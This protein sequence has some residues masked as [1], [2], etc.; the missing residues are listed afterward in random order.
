[1]ESSNN[2]SDS[3]CLTSMYQASK[4]VED[5]AKQTFLFIDTKYNLNELTPAGRL[6][7]EALTILFSHYIAASMQT[8]PN[9]SPNSKKWYAWTKVT[10]V[11]HHWRVVALGSPGLWTDIV[12]QNQAIVEEFLRRSGSAPLHIKVPAKQPNIDALVSVLASFNHIRSIEFLP[13]PYPYDQ[14]PEAS[15]PDEAGQIESIILRSSSKPVQPTPTVFNKCDLSSLRRLH[16]EGFLVDWLH[17][18]FTPNLTH[19]Y[20]TADPQEGPEHSTTMAAMVKSLESMTSLRSLEFHNI[21]FPEWSTSLWD[22]N[23]TTFPQT[24]HLPALKHLTLVCNVSACAYLLRLLRFAGDVTLQIETTAS[25]LPDSIAQRALKFFAESLYE[26]FAESGTLQ[27]PKA[28]EMR[29]RWKTGFRCWNIPFSYQV[30]KSTAPSLSVTFLKNGKKPE[31]VLNAV[32]I[33]VPLFDETLIISAT[34]SPK[35][36]AWA[37]I[38]DKMFHVTRIFVS[39]GAW[40]DLPKMLSMHHISQHRNYDSKS[41]SDLVLQSLETIHFDDGEFNPKVGVSFDRLIE[42]LRERKAAKVGIKTFHLN[43][44]INTKWTTIKKFRPSVRDVIWDGVERKIEWGFY[45]DSDIDEDDVDDLETH[46]FTFDT[47]YV[48]FSLENVRG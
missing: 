44:C 35:R 33:A 40:K 24:V 30:Y 34:F 29:P 45:E 20:V 6:S 17:P 31:T 1:M 27:Y 12:V 18:I 43:N 41:G 19:L 48:P 14:I 28:I 32:A 16:L 9:N 7:P 13:G 8:H 3:S 15:F 22:L 10:H 5:V 21:D 46:P 4:P 26:K 47:W 36:R 38:L 2:S 25:D 39:G 37:P 23:P 42:S 11:C